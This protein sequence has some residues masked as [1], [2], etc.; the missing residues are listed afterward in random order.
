[1]VLIDEL[2]KLTS[3]EADWT[4]L[5]FELNATLSYGSDNVVKEVLAFNDVFTEAISKKPARITAEQ[6]KPLI[7]AIRNDLYL[8]SDS[9][10]ER[11]LRFFVKKKGSSSEKE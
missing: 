4:K 11:N 10:E 7:I 3:N 2:S 6:L 1:M 5:R 9:L 8:E